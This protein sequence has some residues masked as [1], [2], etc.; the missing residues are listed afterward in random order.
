MS[1][2]NVDPQEAHRIAFQLADDAHVFTNPLGLA[3][4]WGRLVEAWLRKLLPEDAAARCDGA[5]VVIFTRL[6]PM[7]HVARVSHFS[8]REEL[9]S[10]LMG[11]THIP[12]FMD[13]CFSRMLRGKHEGE[14]VRAVDGGFL[15]FF[16]LATAQQL[17]SYGAPADSPAV[18]LDATRDAAFGAACCAHNWSMLKPIGT[19]HFIE[20]GARYVEEQAALGS[21]G[22][23][24]PLVPYLRR[25]TPGGSAA[26]NG[27]WR[28][29][30]PPLPSVTDR[31]LVSLQLARRLLLSI[32]VLV[33]CA[34]LLASLAGAGDAFG[35]AS[36][37]LECP[38]PGYW[39]Y[40]YNRGD[41]RVSAWC[42]FRSAA[43]V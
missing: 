11:S 40:L 33:L 39:T 22:E 6:T 1:R 24:A 4:K 23:L 42:A 32:G 35:V 7:P 41:E 34:L 17:L 26:A 10:S 15:E 14:V 30:L 2:C 43:Y 5:S 20:Y 18:V 31:R 16:G 27:S 21:A 8:S 3:C 25:D 36:R 37:Y 29:P 28:R 19:E 9:I 12:F 13:G 38:E